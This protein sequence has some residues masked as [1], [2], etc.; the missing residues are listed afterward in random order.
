MF[1][2]LGQDVPLV[3]FPTRIT[4]DPILLNYYL[5]YHRITRFTAVPTTLRMLTDLK[6]P[7]DLST[8]SI[9]A[10]A[11]KSQVS[12]PPLHVISSSGE[13]LSTWLAAQ[14]QKLFPAARRPT[15]SFWIL[16]DCITG[17]QF[18]C[19]HLFSAICST[20]TSISV[21]MSITR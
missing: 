13:P 19:F 11:N 1:G 5:S 18:T 3:T 17:R 15:A 4:S 14:L 12:M 9:T 7:N 10:S 6:W 8:R 20:F 2:P 16:G 21:P